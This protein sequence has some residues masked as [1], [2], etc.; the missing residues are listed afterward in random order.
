M[1]KNIGYQYIPHTAKDK[2]SKTRVNDRKA[3]AGVDNHR[4]RVLAKI[5]RGI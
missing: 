4:P 3:W 2:S 5:S 1:N